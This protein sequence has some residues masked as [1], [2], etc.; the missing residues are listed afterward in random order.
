MLIIRIQ[1][2]FRTY[3]RDNNIGS[4]IINGIC[5]LCCCSK[6]GF[7]GYINGFGWLR[8]GAIQ[9]LINCKEV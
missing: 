1:S 8:N 3:F 2:K 9:I 6:A 7:C 4:T 5:F